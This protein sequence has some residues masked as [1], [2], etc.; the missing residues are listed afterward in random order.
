M[1]KHRAATFILLC[2]MLLTAVHG[3]AWPGAL[4]G[5]AEPAPQ[6]EWRV[7]QDGP[8]TCDFSVIQDAVDAAS[9]GD[10][11]KVAVG[12]YNTLN[13]HG[14]LAQVVYI[15]KTVFLRGGYTTAFTEPPD[16]I[17]HP[18]V[19][20]AQGGGRVVL[21]TA[22]SSLVTPVLEGFEITRGDATGLGGGPWG[23]DGVGGG[24]YVVSATAAISDCV[25]H[26]NYGSTAGYG[27]GGGVY[28]WWSDSLLA[29]NKIW[30]NIAG[31]NPSGL[32]EGGGVAMSESA[33]VLLGNDIHDN[34]ANDA[35]YGI[36][37][38]IYMECFGYP[39]KPALYRNLIWSNWASGSGGRGS[40]GG[41]FAGYGSNPVMENNVLVSNTSG[42]TM[43]S[44]GAGLFAEYA[45]FTMI[46]TTIDAN[47]GYDSN[48]VYADN[49]N[50]SMVNTIVVFQA[51]TAVEADA[52]SAVTVNGVLWFSNGSNTGGAGT[53]S[54]TGAITGNPNLSADGYHVLSPSLAIDNGVPTAVTDDIDGQARPNGAGPDL[55]ADEYYACVPVNGVTID[56]P[57]SGYAGTSY[58][59]EAVA[60]PPT[61]SY[62]FLYTWY[63]TPTLVTD[64]VAF[65]EWAVPG[66]YTIT[67]R[68]ENCGG[69]ATDTHAIVITA[70]PTPLDGVEIVGPTEVY[71][72]FPVP[73]YA[74]T[75]PP[76]IVQPVTYTWTPAPNLGQGTPFVEYTWASTGTHIVTVSAESCG[77]VVSNTLAVLAR[78]EI[79][80]TVYPT[81]GVT[82]VYTDLQGIST[83][84]AIPAGAVTET[85]LLVFAPVF[86]PSYPV[87]PGLALANHNFDLNAYR[88]G[89]LPGFVFDRPVTITVNYSDADV[90]W[91]YEDTLKLY[92]WDGAAWADGAETCVPPSTYLRDP[93]QNV[94]QV[95]ICHLTQWG[96]MGGPLPRH[97]VYLPLV[98]R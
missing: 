75:D 9:D 26:S 73:Y 54:V 90:R 25:I 27:G 47:N 65:Y 33:A 15:S 58:A 36:G 41:I 21:I 89:L 81:V 83:T 82:L 51:G 97:E 91:L 62:P 14:G 92:Y 30:A 66:A 31:T 6:G 57:S 48:G 11:I 85:T 50:I 93:A 44:A 88:G 13:N 70:C 16:P 96:M 77:N 59:F 56:G 29:G 46:H 28:L 42:G 45:D 23:Y 67:V 86:S 79:T 12:T 8:P 2:G 61:A 22:T 94:L 49:S 98:Y 39:Y 1:R 34:F 69:V 32:S 4:V 3:V 24:I 64:P 63:P 20:D 53:I 71:V 72:G 84:V 35:G 87:S 43:D 17:A 40:G 10:T 60:D 55:G 37:G 80:G 68:L 95:A 5:N 78:S 7:C 38:G 76:S 74:E 19:L 52:G 18:T